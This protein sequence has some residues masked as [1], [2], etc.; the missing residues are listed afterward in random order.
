MA[1]ARKKLSKSTY[2]LLAIIFIAV[3]VAVVL[4]FTY[5]AVGFGIDLNFIGDIAIALISFGAS[6]GWSAGIVLAIPFVVGM[7]CFYALKAYFI[8]EKQVM[9]GTIAP[10]G[11]NPQ[12]STPSQPQQKD[13]TVISA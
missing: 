13:E 3:I 10:S 6:S 5:H 7:L 11:Y 9:I 12:P 2:I 1:V 4:H 8:G